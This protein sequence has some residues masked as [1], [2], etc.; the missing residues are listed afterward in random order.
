MHG[1]GV[2][3]AVIMGFTLQTW[4]SA[5]SSAGDYDWTPHSNVNLATILALDTSFPCHGK[6]VVRLLCVFEDRDM[7]IVWSKEG[8]FQLDLSNMWWKKFYRIKSGCTLFS[9][10]VPSG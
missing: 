8:V 10:S 1:G 5:R 3:L 7:V 4:S 6:H 2:G 9:Y